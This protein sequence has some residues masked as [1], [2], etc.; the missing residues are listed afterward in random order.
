M[1]DTKVIRKTAAKY[2]NQLDKIG[3][4][5]KQRIWKDNYCINTDLFMLLQ[6]IGKF[7]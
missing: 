1:E 2:L 3:I 4:L 7:S 5:S 6:N